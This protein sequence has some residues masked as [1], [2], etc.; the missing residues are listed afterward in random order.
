MASGGDSG[1]GVGREAPSVGVYL[2]LAAVSSSRLPEIAARVEQLGFES[3]WVG[4]HVVIPPATDA[5]P[6]NNGRPPF[7]PGTHFVDPLVLFGFLAGRTSTLR[8]GTA[9]SVLPQREPLTFA[10]Q[11]VTLDVLTG[12]RILVGVGAG[13]CREEFDALGQDFATRG[14][15]LDEEIEILRLTGRD[16]SIDFRGRYY[17]FGPVEFEPKPT[18]QPFPPILVGGESDAALRRAAAVGDGWLSGERLEPDQLAVI[19]ERLRNMRLES[20]RGGDS[21]SVTVPMYPHPD[22]AAWLTALCAAGADR[23]LLRIEDYEEDHLEAF[24][25]DVA[26][27]LSSD[28]HGRLQGRAGQADLTLP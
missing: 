9:V 25:A 4:D 13:W 24:A 20:G 6:Y 17:R 21:F 22:S 26:A 1:H 11:V 23:V 10:K 14:A 7:K 12:G 18:T 8:F 28:A 2:G 19:V 5:Y 15:R 27:S 16:G 3:F